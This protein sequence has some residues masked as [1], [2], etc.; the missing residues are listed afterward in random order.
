MA[1][2]KTTIP[3]VEIK[4]KVEASLLRSMSAMDE[5]IHLLDRL[6]TKTDEKNAYKVF[7]IKENTKHILQQYDMLARKR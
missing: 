6:N 2:S 5:A 7:K 4:Q 3:R 1:N